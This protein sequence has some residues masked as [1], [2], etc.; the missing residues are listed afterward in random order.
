VQTD[1][2]LT[3]L[4]ITTQQSSLMAR[5]TS[6]KLRAQTVAANTW[7]VSFEGAESNADANAFLAVSCYVWRP[8]TSAVVGFIRD[9]AATLGV[10]FAGTPQSVTFA[11]SA[12]TAN[13]QDVLVLEAWVVA[14]QGSTMTRTI[15]WSTGLLAANTYA[16]IETPQNLSW[17]TF[18]QFSL[19]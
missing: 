8:S 4:G 10:E 18:N 15:T 6:P 5:Y 19:V 12:V 14:T 9:S 2:T 7:T 11:G 1:Y 13:A 3:S 17:F 16:Y